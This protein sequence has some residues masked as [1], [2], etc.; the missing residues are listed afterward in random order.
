MRRKD[1]EMPRDFGLAVLDKCEWAVL[2]MVDG[3]EPYAVPVSIVRD[4]NYLYFHSAFEGR[5]VDVLRR[6]PRV[7]LSAV[8]S[9]R[10]VPEEF[11][12][13]FESAF[14]TGTAVEVTGTEEKTRALRL[15]C[16]R[17]APTN[18]ANFDAALAESLP[19]TAVFRVEIEELTAKRKKYDSRGKELKFGATEE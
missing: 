2:S 16:G 1:R 8:G 17:Y 7:C 18:V 13:E 3:A 4:G 11:T 12:T 19:R 14:V 10:L 9:T 15:I 6:A 5:K